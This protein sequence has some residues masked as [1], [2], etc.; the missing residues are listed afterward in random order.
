MVLT[1]TSPLLLAIA[2]IFVR[3]GRMNAAAARVGEPAGSTVV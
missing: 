3:L 2:A 1:V